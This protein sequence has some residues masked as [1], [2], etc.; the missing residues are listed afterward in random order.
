MPGVEFHGETQNMNAITR[1]GNL[2]HRK[3]CFKIS[4]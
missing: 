1:R 2:P 4:N 3:T